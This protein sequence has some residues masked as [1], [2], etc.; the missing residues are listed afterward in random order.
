MSLA[1]AKGT[2]NIE[3]IG[4][5]AFATCRSLSEFNWPK[6]CKFFGE[7][8]F[9]YATEIAGEIYIPAD[10][11]VND[12]AFTG[13]SAVTSLTID[14]NTEYVGEGA[15]CELEALQ[16]V[17]VN[18][19]TPPSFS[20]STVFGDGWDEADLSG[21][22]LYVPTGSKTNYESNADWGD[23]FGA[24][25]EKEFETSGGTGGGGTGDN[26]RTETVLEDKISDD[27]TE[28]TIHVAEAGTLS[29][30]LTS[31]L[32]KTVKKL[33][34]SGKLNGTDFNIIRK[35]A[36][37]NV[38]GDKIDGAQ[39]EC[40]DLQYADI[41]EGG[42]AYFVS[43]SGSYY[44]SDDVIGSFLFT[45]C[46]S[47]KTIVLPKYT[48]KLASNA[49]YNATHLQDITF[50]PNLKYIGETCFYGCN[51]LETVDLPEK[52]D[53]LGDQV[54]YACSAL[55]HVGL[56]SS[57]RNI[58]FATFYFCTSLNDIT[59][60]DGITSLAN[61]AFFNCKSLKSIIIPK[62]VNSISLSAFSRCSSL[63]NFYVDADNADFKSI[64][65][66]LFNKLGTVLLNYPLGN[67]RETYALPEGTLSVS[68][69]AF[70]E[71]NLKGVTFNETLQSI[72]ETA[73][74]DC[75]QLETVVFG[76]SLQK[77]GRGAFS[78]D[79]SLK[80]VSLPKS[81]SC[82]G[83]G[84][85]S[86]CT[87]LTD[88]AVPEQITE[89][90]TSMC[91]GCTALKSVYIP[92]NV[93]DIDGN[94][95]AGCTSLEK[96]TVD[97]VC[98]PLC[99]YEDDTDTNTPFAGVDVANVLLEVPE[100]SVASYQAANV[101]KNFKFNNTTAIHALTGCDKQVVKTTY[102]DLDGRTIERPVRGL[103]IKNQ[104][105]S[106]GSTNKVKVVIR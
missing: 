6:K 90:T 56:P 17:N 36:G 30:V 88:F 41:Q 70:W 81:V 5:Q 12:G 80:T 73:M 15:F 33:T 69:D 103:Y 60:P 54:F 51:E 49:F 74:S 20:P 18:C 78:S 94:A 4:S 19:T 77:I 2:E 37:V 63:E 3:R 57:L 25:E 28:V 31:K 104:I 26:D 29:D 1:E 11:T 76:N 87:S 14:G 97:A 99:Y 32:R 106:D 66:V 59:L 92:S 16:T 96:V 48:E 67:A 22:T 91:D 8:S 40:L 53:K 89:I 45:C 42:D 24:I 98:P 10:A 61:Y 64:D 38:S 105:F 86:Y 46:Y 65:G 7:K 13:M 101:W 47:L 21:V 72:G 43:T 82:I 68:D 39:L 84:A 85:F 34:L 52:L 55:K 79:V 95:F 50:N 75:K 44:T 58:P 100:A 27:G 9:T 62:N 23:V 102:T 83:E 71:A 93:T 35:L